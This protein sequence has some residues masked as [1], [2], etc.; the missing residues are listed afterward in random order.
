MNKFN[1]IRQKLYL[2][3][4]ALEKLHVIC[5]NLSNIGFIFIIS[6]TVFFCLNDKVKRNEYAYS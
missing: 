3:Q 5:D 2:Y 4:C 6:G 1:Y